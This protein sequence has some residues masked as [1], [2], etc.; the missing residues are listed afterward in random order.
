MFKKIKEAMKK[1]KLWIKTQLLRFH[2]WVAS[3]APGI[4]TKVITGLG[5]IGSTAALLQ[6]F[7]S[8]LPLST[9]IGATEALIVTSVLFA[10]A[11]WFR[12]MARN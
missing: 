8:G 9:I 11:F 7:V 12:S 5:F 4:K 1:V 6:E 2:N 10:L 3:K